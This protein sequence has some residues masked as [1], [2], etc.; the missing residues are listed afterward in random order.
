MAIG[1]APM[2][3][4]TVIT[5]MCVGM[6]IV[7]G[8]IQT[9]GAMRY[10][11]KVIDRLADPALFAIGPA[12]ILGLLVSMLHMHDVTNMF[13]VIRHWDSSW[14]SRE[15][16]FGI[17]FA[18][19]GF[20]FCIMQVLKLG[21]VRLR[22]VV[23][24]LTAVVGVG[25]VVAQAQ[26][27]Y[28]LATIPAWHHWATWV[29]FFGTALLLGS[30]GVGTTFVLLIHKRD[31]RV[32]KMSQDDLAK[33]DEPHESG[34][35]SERVRDFFTDRHLTD[36]ATREQVDSLLTTAVRSVVSVAIVAAGVILI[37]MQIYVPDLAQSGLSGLEAAGSYATGFAMVRFALLV[38]GALVLGL[39]AFFFVGASP[40]KLGLVAAILGSAF[41]LV[42]ISEFMGRALFYGAMTAV[43]I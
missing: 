37:A 1:E 25:L 31:R 9:I 8:A 43:G 39:A 40:K 16:L 36:S 27:Y 29:Q 12:M 23:A 38:A 7:L 18:A 24:V 3:F 15:I 5:Q 14:L 30:L 22:Q 32:A 42:L 20:L 2:I 4:F 6:F 34:S 21:S 19:L 35:L 41:I 33:L 17:G 10:P 28:S 13:N 26:I 11:A